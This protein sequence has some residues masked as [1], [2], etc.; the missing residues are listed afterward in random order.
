MPAVGL[1][2]YT[3]PMGSHLE[4]P[5]R[6]SAGHTMIVTSPLSGGKEREGKGKTMGWNIQV[7]GTI[8]SLTWGTCLL[9]MPSHG[10]AQEP[11]APTLAPEAPAV[12]TE[13]HLTNIRQLTFSGKNAEAYFSSSGHQLV[14][15]STLEPDGKTQ[16]GCYQIY[17][18]NLEG[19]NVYRVSTGTGGTTCG[20]FF[21]GDRRVL[22]SSTHINSTLCPP[23][24]P[25]GERYRWALDDYDLF[26]MSLKGWDLQRLTATPG[27]D[28]EATISPDGRTIVWTSMRDGDLDIYTMKLDGTNVKR[29]T[30]TIGYDGG[31]FFSP[32]SKRLVYRAN[33]PATDQEVKAYQD[34]LAKNLVEPSHMELFIMNADGS[35]QTQITNNGKANFAPYFLP[36][37]K[38]VIFASNLSTPEGHHGP[39]SFHLYTINDD[40]TGLEQITF[41]GHFNSFPMFSPDGTQLVWSSD[42]NAAAK[43]EYNIFLA[44]WV[45]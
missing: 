2:Q 23:E 33:H 41:E 30:E 42:R 6:A 39:P 45:P 7:G 15:Q 4:I 11:T 21:P 3:Q 10:W 25:R 28:A 9:L 13:R 40:G 24:P 35:N 43:G 31:A 16:R 20:Y 18:M 29:L 1:T 34:L 26:T 38:G 36:H 44:D 17:I 37:G 12:Q 5:N 22:F 19:A 27:Y 32:D 14:Y 8:R